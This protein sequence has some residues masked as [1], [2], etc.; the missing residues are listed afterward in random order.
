M[1]GPADS[2]STEATFKPE[3]HWGL[4]K[5]S[6]VELMVLVIGVAL[7]ST[8]RIGMLIGI[9]VALGALYSGF[10]MAPK[11]KRGI[12]VGQ[13]PHCGADMSAMHY[14]EQVDCPSCGHFVT[15]KDSRFIAASDPV[16]KAA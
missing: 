8:G 9:P 6:A 3:K 11:F 13:C 7:C 16:E 5:L 4:A 15:V 1:T 12:Y 14:Q 10:F 2:K